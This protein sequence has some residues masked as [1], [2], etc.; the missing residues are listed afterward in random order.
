[1]S[2]VTLRI[3][4]EETGLSKFAVSRALS[5]KSGVSEATRARVSEAAARLGYRAQPAEAKALLLGAIFD[6]TEAVNSEL[7]MQIQSG[8]QREATR[9][10]YGVRLQWTHSPGDLEHMAA[11]CDGML[12]VGRHPGRSLARAYAT[13]TPIVRSGWLDSLE[14]AD[15]VGGTDHEA[16]VAVAEMLM[17]RGHRHIVFVHGR[18][19][20]RGRRERFLGLSAAVQGSDGAIA[21]DMTFP[22]EAGFARALDAYLATGARPTA[23]FCAHDGLAL[24]VITE[25]MRRGVRIPED[26]SVVGFGDFS[27]ARQIRPGLTTVKVFGVNFGVAAVRLLDARL[28]LPE[29]PP[30]PIRVQLPNR[31][32]ERGTVAAAPAP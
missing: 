10:G 21:H 8:V 7:Y 25:L 18:D 22:D 1:M 12:V 23:Y 26:A 32:V 29:Y 3:I 28:R 9:L 13:G 31:I 6:D 19:T 15:S 11:E 17:S 30:F 27:A 16:G 5:G 20:L 4:A 14:Q 2:R 24:T